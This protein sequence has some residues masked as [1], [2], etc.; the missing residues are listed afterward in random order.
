VL[1]T[2]E[3]RKRRNNVRTG[4]VV[5]TEP[6]FLK[7]KRMKKVWPICQSVAPYLVF[8]IIISLMFLQP[9]DG[10]EIW[11]YNF[12]R[13]IA[14]G[15]KPYRDIS[16]VQTPLAA[17]LAALFLKVFGDALIVFRMLGAILAAAVFSFTYYVAKQIQKDWLM[18][19]TVCSFLAMF[20]M[21]AW[22]YNYNNLNLLLVVLLMYL[23]YRKMCSVKKKWIYVLEGLVFGATPLIKQNTGIFIF[24][25]GVLFCIYEYLRKNNRKEAVMQFGASVCPGLLYVIYLFISGTLQSFF[26]YAVLGIREFSHKMTVQE[27][28]KESWFGAVFCLVFFVAVGF[29][30]YHI[31]CEKNK[32]TKELR[33]RILLLALASSTVLY[34]LWD[35]YHMLCALVPYA[36]C[37]I[38]TERADKKGVSHR[39]KLYSAVGVFACCVVIGVGF[40]DNL[41]GECNKLS[42]LDRYQWIPMEE[43]VEEAVIEIDEYILQKK[44]EGIDVLITY[45]GAALFMV[46][47]GLYHK[48]YD[49]LLVGNIGTQSVEDLLNRNKETLYLVPKNLS[50]LQRQSHYELIH[51]I[52]ENYGKVDE[53][54]AFDVYAKQ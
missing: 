17:Y 22:I 51:F 49:M 5:Y 54:G 28:M 38:G 4:S 2:K 3:E 14:K 18:P 44:A 34:P 42:S 30:I 33:I 25:V 39:T 11:N 15:L 29:S 41:L 24:G 27:C 53:I 12:A 13:S 23:Q 21:L 43:V 7:G 9:I 36:V 32:E 47:L 50:V 19:F 45:E 37:S 20:N 40:A 26:D 35:L 31:I 1:Y 52:I 10:D 8:V 16:M 48:D 6:V 46:P